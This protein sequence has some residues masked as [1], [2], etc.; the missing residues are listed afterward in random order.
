MQDASA[1]SETTSLRFVSE[2]ER[3]IQGQHRGRKKGGFAAGA[4]PEFTG[5]IQDAVGSTPFAA[6][7][8]S[9]DG[10]P[11]DHSYSQHEPNEAKGLA[12]LRSR[13]SAVREK[14][15][16]ELGFDISKYNSES[17][18][19]KRQGRDTPPP[20]DSLRRAFAKFEAANQYFAS[21]TS[22]RSRAATPTVTMP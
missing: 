13:E 17:P 4:M 12:W 21:P 20:P 3:I 14:L 11:L 10:K 8:Q 9:V 18:A 1:Q 6:S 5:S 22:R 2:V 19:R 16:N 7:S 15:S